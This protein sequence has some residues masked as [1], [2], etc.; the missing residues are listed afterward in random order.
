MSEEWEVLKEAVLAYARDVSG[1]RKLGRLE[2]VVTGRM[3]K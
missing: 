1:I 2:S 3:M